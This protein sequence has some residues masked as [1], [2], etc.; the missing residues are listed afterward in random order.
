MNY[1]P[2][3][4]METIEGK[5]PKVSRAQ[6]LYSICAV[7]CIVFYGCVAKRM[8]DAQIRDT[9][10]VVMTIVG[11]ILMVIVGFSNRHKEDKSFAWSNWAVATVIFGGF[12]LRYVSYFLI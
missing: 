4:R 3:D 11:I 7:L 12:I 5:K 9:I 2:E 1:L 8:T 10:F 6:L